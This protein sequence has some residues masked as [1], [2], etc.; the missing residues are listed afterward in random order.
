MYAPTHGK[1]FFAFISY[2]DDNKETAEDF[3]KVLK[4]FF[5]WSTIFLAHRD[6][7]RG[8]NYEDNLKKAIKNCAVFIPLISKEFLES[9][10]ANQEVGLAV[11]LEKMIYPVKLDNADPPAF[12]HLLHAPK[13]DL[14]VT[15]G[16]EVEELVINIIKKMKMPTSDLVLQSLYIGNFY[17]TDI[18]SKILMEREDY[19]EDDIRILKLAYDNNPQIYNCASGEDIANIIEKTE[20][21]FDGEF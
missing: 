2:A 16:G 10:Y 13:L 8:E 1:K 17:H 5:P 15:K 6:L 3:S 11:A 9:S 4:R 12:I 7:E 21:K 18:I 20:R 19:A 14:N